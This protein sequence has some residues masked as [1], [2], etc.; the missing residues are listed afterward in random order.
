MSMKPDK[1]NQ[2]VVSVFDNLAKAKQAQKDIEMWDE[3]Q[4]DVKL[5]GSAIIYK[6]TDGKI[7]HEQS[8]KFDWKKGT[9]IGLLLVPLTGGVLL[10][11]FGAASGLAAA[12]LKGIKREDV[13]KIATKVKEGKA[14]LAI[15]CDEYEVPMVSVE[16]NR[17]GGTA[18]TG[19]Q[20]PAKTASDV[21]DAVQHAEDEGK[22]KSHSIVS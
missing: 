5:G 19:Y 7:K 13:D 17:L 12:W 22:L 10:P 8:S 3:A 9:L 4:P 15:L 20:V 6:D 14:A 2:L 21:Q 16:L 1:N 11:V 18:I